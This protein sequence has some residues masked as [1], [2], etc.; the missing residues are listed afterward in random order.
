MQKIISLQVQ[1]QQD[2]YG[3]YFTIDSSNN[4][5]Y[6][7]ISSAGFVDAVQYNY[8]LSPN[9]MA[10]NR[11]IDIQEKILGI[12]LIPNSEYVYDAK[13]KIKTIQGQIDIGAFEYQ[14]TAALADHHENR[15]E[16]Y[17]N[18]V[19]STLTIRFDLTLNT[20]PFPV[21]YKLSGQKCKVDFYK[22]D[23]Q[24]IHADLS[25]IPSGIYVLEYNNV[26]RKFV[27]R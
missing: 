19:N 4:L 22:S 17:P 23:D 14:G 15:F 12:S 6:S 8:H 21:I 18:P 9:S 27:V 11:G 25:Q 24:E 5:H 3:E 26:K 16:L 20:Y 13:Y 7:M 1:T 10:I 2:L